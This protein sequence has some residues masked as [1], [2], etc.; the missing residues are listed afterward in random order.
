MEIDNS[1][2]PEL[3]P[4]AKRVGP[5]VGAAVVAIAGIGYAVHEHSAAQAVIAQKQTLASQNEQVSAQL[6]ATQAELAALAAKVDALATPAEAKPSPAVSSNGSRGT[7]TNHRSSAAAHGV[8]SHDPRYERMQAQLDEQGRKIDATRNDLDSTRTDLVNTR[9]E[10][11]GSIAKTHDEL[12]VLEKRGQRS[13]FEFDLTKSKDFK[14]E[15]P[16]SISLR[17]ANDKKG[18][19][20]LA[21]I[22]DDRNLTQKHVNLYQPAMFYQPD[23]PQPVEIVINDI[24]KNH[25]HGYVSAPKYRNSELAATSTDSGNNSPS[26]QAASATD[27]PPA[28]QKLPLPSSDSNL[29]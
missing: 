13:Y 15:G 11:T 6:S 4:I 1:S 20:D 16:I 17:K 5:F 22:V 9:T 23:R 28:R 29:E 26:G 18:Y 12:I 3:S 19:A 27:Q 25:I 21:L 24:S 8:N 2:F 10:L 7:A 14:R